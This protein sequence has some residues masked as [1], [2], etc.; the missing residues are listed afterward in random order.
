M[1]EFV[2]LSSENICSLLPYFRNPASRACDNTIGAVY[3]WRNVYNTHIAELDGLLLIRAAYEAFGEGYT[4]PLGVGDY[5]RALSCMEADA[6]ARGVP[7]RLSVVPEFALPFLRERYGERMR[8][9]THRDW[10]D[11]I[12][13]PENFRAYAGKSLH[14]QRNHVNRFWREHRAA[15]VVPVTQVLLPACLEFLDAYTA[16]NDP[17]DA[18]AVAE[19][20]GAR[21]L[22]LLGESLGQMAY[23][24]AEQGRIAALTIGER[25]GDTLV[26][27][28]EKALSAYSGAYPAMAQGFVRA[29][30][31]TVAFVNREDD[32]GDAG[33]RYSKTNYRPLYL[34]D[35]YAITVV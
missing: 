8:A 1:S 24:I 9:Q 19:T 22:L 23:C 3:Q 10:A 11:Y 7:F 15:E 13:K 32:A 4:Y 33:L 27:H 14:A 21:D 17:T 29:V 2:A 20:E 26:I 18:G 35:K 25:V 5:A 16:E 28:V 6:K 30:G 34:L 12:Y 31:E